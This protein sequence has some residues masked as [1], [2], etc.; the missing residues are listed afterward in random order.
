MR[1]FKISSFNY[2]DQ[3]EAKGPEKLCI[4]GGKEGISRTVF[5]TKSPRKV[6]WLI[7]FSFPP[8]N[9]WNRCVCSCSL[10]D[11]N[12]TSISSAAPWWG[13]RFESSSGGAL[14]CGGSDEGVLTWTLVS[15]WCPGSRVTM[16]S[17]QLTHPPALQMQRSLGL[18]FK[19]W[20]GLPWCNC[21]RV[22]N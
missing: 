4:E 6:F 1:A 2:K 12:I 8:V 21:S 15:G 20:I 18:C 16:C 14:G 7:F 9:V 5:G 19:S 13:W 22:L 10:W 11:Q 17:V 3:L